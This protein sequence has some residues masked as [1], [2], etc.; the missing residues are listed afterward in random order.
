MPPR[1]A[2]ASAPKKTYRFGAFLRLYGPRGAP[3]HAKLVFGHAP[4][5]NTPEAFLAE[6]AEEREYDYLALRQGLRWR[7]R[8]SLGD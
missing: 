3:T 4:R 2:K 6:L 5:P 7:Y 8:P 1:T